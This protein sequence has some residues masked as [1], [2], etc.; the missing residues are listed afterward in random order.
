[1]KPYKHTF[2]LLDSD[3]VIID[4]KD[5]SKFT[6]DEFC[7]WINNSNARMYTNDRPRL[8][9]GDKVPFSDNWWSYWSRHYDSTIHDFNPMLWDHIHTL[10]N[11]WKQWGEENGVEVILDIDGLT[12][13]P[14][15]GAYG[16]ATVDWQITFKNRF[17]DQTVGFKSL[18]WD[19]RH[20]RGLCL[21]PSG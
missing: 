13:P 2:I 10:Y 12:R 15:E 14:R 17:C 16:G 9:I 8:N 11:G 1:M 21:R 3:R 7:D 6:W 20:D 18:V 5:V 4:R 19:G